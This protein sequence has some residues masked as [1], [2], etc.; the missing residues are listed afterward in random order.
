MCIWKVEE[1][2]RHCDICMYRGGCENR[3]IV[4]TVDEAGAR[5]SS[6]ML[7]VSGVDVR[8]RSRLREVVWA[9]NMVCY[10]LLSDGFTEA[11]VGRFVGLN[12]STVHYI[13]GQVESMLQNPN[14][15][16]NEMA[17]WKKF[18]EGIVSF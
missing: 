12:H 16:R 15:F 10:Q 13:K 1:S 4:E 8:M 11:S 17:V 3:E 6:V 2:E 9:R 18:Q 14:Y 5:Y 7:R